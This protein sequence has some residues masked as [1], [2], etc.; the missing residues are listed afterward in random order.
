MSTLTDLIAQRDALNAKIALFATFPEDVYNLGT[1]ALFVYQENTQHI[2]YRKTAVELWKPIANSA[3]GG[4]PLSDWIYDFKTGFPSEYFE[5]YI[6]A[7]GATP[8]YASA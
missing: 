1:V 2:Y 6:M 8:I 4:K 7:P 5:V 3:T